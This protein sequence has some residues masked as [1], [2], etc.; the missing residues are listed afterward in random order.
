MIKLSTKWIFYA[1]LISLFL[2]YLIG[3]A[4]TVTY[5]ISYGGKWC[6]PFLAF[7]SDPLHCSYVDI[8]FYEPVFSVFAW[9]IVSFGLVSLV[10]IVGIAFWGISVQR[11]RIIDNRIA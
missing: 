6:R 2:Q 1:I 9:N 10:S 11:K 7:N 8:F 3:L 4:L 5:A